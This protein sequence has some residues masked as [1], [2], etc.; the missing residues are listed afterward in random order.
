MPVFQEENKKNIHFLK[1]KRIK[2]SKDKF[3]QFI[4]VFLFLSY[5]IVEYAYVYTFFKCKLYLFKDF[6]A[7]IP[8]KNNLFA[9]KSFIFN[10]KKSYILVKSYKITIY[11]Q[12]M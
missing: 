11:I 1:I 3:A 10:F 2:I 8:V 9:L 4:K 7:N 6:S 12:T 5:I